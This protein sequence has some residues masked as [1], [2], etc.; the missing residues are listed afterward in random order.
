[1]TRKDPAL[2][3]FGSDFY[4]DE[5]VLQMDLEQQGA[6]LRLLWLAWR[7][8]GLPTDPACLAK[9]LHVSLKRFT[10]RIWPAIQACWHEQDG[11]LRQKRQEQERERRQGRDQAPQDG[12]P[13]PADRSER[14]RQLAQRRWG[15]GDADANT[16]AAT[17]AGDAAPHAHADAATHADADAERNAVR[18]AARISP[19]APPLCTN[20]VQPQ[21]AHARPHAHAD[22]QPASA[23][24]ASA[25]RAEPRT[26]RGRRG[27]ESFSHPVTDLVKALFATAYRSGSGNELQRRFA[28]NQEAQRLVQTGLDASHVAQLN[29]L[30]K[31]NTKGDSGALLAHWLDGNKWR[32]VLDEQ[33]AK[34]K[35]RD[36]Q[37]RT[38]QAASD[39]V[40][41]GM[42]GETSAEAG[43]VVAQVLAG[44]APTQAQE[45]QA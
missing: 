18:N 29:D 4:E 16:H 44:V 32:E 31:K 45:A 19:P 10:A 9:M 41:Q 20:Q 43:S 35:Q 22:A 40:L 17:H 42:Y 25:E 27:I 21:D 30:A 34:Q 26:R 14:M 11:R 1:V 8:D 3:L 13:Q 28:L 5:D 38:K 12:Q 39:D 15:R 2:L 24:G 23:S 6:Y 36:I 7:N 37:I 33:N